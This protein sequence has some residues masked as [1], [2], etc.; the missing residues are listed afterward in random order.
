[1]ATAKKPVSKSITKP[2]TNQPVKNNS[3][4]TILTKEML[5]FLSYN[6]LI[7]DDFIN[8]LSTNFNI[9]KLDVTNIKFVELII[10]HYFDEF[11]D[12]LYELSMFV[13]DNKLSNSKNY[14]NLKSR[15]NI[16][17]N[18]NLHK[19]D[20]SDIKSIVCND[21]DS[22]LW[23]RV[24]D[25]CNMASL[26]HTINISDKELKTEFNRVLTTL[27]TEKNN[28]K[29]EVIDIIKHVVIFLNTEIDLRTIQ[30]K[31]DKMEYYIEVKRRLDELQKSYGHSFTEALKDFKTN[32][33]K[34]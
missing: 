5:Q 7:C 8:A 15:I 22:I 20:S 4:N 26:Q 25:N 18:N 24:M 19:E 10:D 23:D 14:I 28:L 13:D 29:K 33:S 9:N 21:F 12:F 31:I 30:E 17:Y 34:K 16:L 32:E 2:K 27:I 1:M 11:V 3:E 6:D